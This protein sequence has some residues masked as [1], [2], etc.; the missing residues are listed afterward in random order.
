MD[1]GELSEPLINLI[2]KFSKGNINLQQFL[3]THVEEP[4]RL[5]YRLIEKSIP[6]SIKIKTFLQQNNIYSDKITWLLDA[7]YITNQVDMFVQVLS[8][9]LYSLTKN[10]NKNK[11]EIIA[12]L[13]A[14]LDGVY[15][16]RI[17]LVY[18]DIKE[19]G[20]ELLRVWFGRIY[21]DLFEGDDKVLEIK[22][23]KLVAIMSFMIGK[24]LF[25]NN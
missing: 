3:V 15:L 6:K 12:D 18:N 16:E 10:T 20:F 9:A 24:K 1:K 25:E 21:K 14:F 13:D 2:I 8:D 19:K 22:N 4:N 11:R 7:D 23:S 5:L 17:K